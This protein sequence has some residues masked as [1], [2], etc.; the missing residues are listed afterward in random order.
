MHVVPG[1]GS[2]AAIF[3]EPLPGCATIV[4]PEERAIFRLNQR[5]DP[6]RHRRR[7]R[8]ADLANRTLRQ[9]RVA[10]NIRPGVTT[11]GS[12]PEAAIRT[13]AAE[14]VR[15]PLRLPDRD[16]DLTRVLRVHRHIDRASPVADVQDPF[17]GLTAVGCPEDATFIIRS[18]GM[19][20]RGN[21]DD[22]SVLRVYPHPPDV[23][24]VL[25]TNIFPAPAAVGRLVDP[26]AMRDIAA[27]GRLT[28]TDVDHIR[29][30]LSNRDGANGGCLHIAIRDVLPDIPAVR[31]L[32]DTASTCAV[33]ERCPFGR[34]S[35]DGDDTPATEGSGTPPL[36]RFK[37]FFV[38][39]S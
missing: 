18:P 2:Q 31:R 35:G 27:D 16:V 24:G 12:L 39:R 29:V 25:Q 28:G 9:S 11:V 8:D 34:V 22:V 10:G 17:P 37:E 36:Q 7:N 19:P 14:R 5:I 21:V 38:H 3:T 1:A 33:V 13:A 23:P 32:P 30:G 20:E 4:G 26:V 15:I 6:L